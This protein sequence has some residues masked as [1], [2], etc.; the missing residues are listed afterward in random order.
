MRMCIAMR[1]ALLFLCLLTGCSAV[2][3]FDDDDPGQD[4]IGHLWFDVTQ[5]VDPMAV[6]FWRFN[7]VDSLLAMDLLDAL[8]NNIEEAIKKHGDEL[9]VNWPEYATALRQAL[10]LR[11]SM[12][13]SGPTGHQLNMA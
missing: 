6:W 2:Y 3:D 7:E 10:N 11:D 5:D 1:I 9:V 4:D 13:Y 12:G 8:N